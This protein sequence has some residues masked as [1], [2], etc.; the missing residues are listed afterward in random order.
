MVWDRQT[1]DGWL[2]VPRSMPLL[3][4]IMDSLSKG[5]PVSSAYLDLWCRTYDDS[6]VIAGN[7]REMAFFSG[8]TGERAVRTWSSRI[9]ILK[10]LGFIDVKEGPSGP[11]SYILI[12]NPYHV[13]HR[14]YEDN[15]IDS[16]LYCSLEQR[17]MEIG[18]QDLESSA[19]RGS[20]SLPD[21]DENEQVG[22]PPPASGPSASR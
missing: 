4:R 22:N 17:A 15:R 12:F 19:L 7:E 9:T 14:L 2:S 3:M 1:S 5:K 16:I 21:G 20:A 11:I 18:A 6:F 10:E 8:F 13:I